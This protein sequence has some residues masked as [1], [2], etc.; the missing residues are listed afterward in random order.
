M[1]PRVPIGPQLPTPSGP[2]EDDAKVKLE[3]DEAEGEYPDRAV[4]ND[5]KG[6]FR[7]RYV[8][9]AYI[10]QPDSEWDEA[11][12][13]RGEADN[14]EDWDGEPLYND[15]D[16]EA[17]LREACY[18]SL[19]ERYLALR[20][21]L[22][23]KPPHSAVEQLPPSQSYH[24]GYFGPKTSVFSVW[25]HRLRNTDPWPAQV[26]SM[27]KDSV[28]RVLRVLMSGKFLRRGYD[29][30]ERTSRWLWA[31]L[32]RLPDRGEMNHI[33][34]GW[35]RDLGR[36]AVLM[37]QSLTH[38]ANLREALQDEGMDLGVHEG[39]DESSDDEDVLADME[40]EED[41]EE[42]QPRREE[43]SI[44]AETTGNAG[45]A[46]EAPENSS[47]PAPEPKQETAPDDDQKSED[48]D[49]SEDGEV[50]EDEPGP[51]AADKE[52]S[53]AAALEAA[54]ARVLA[55]LE[56]EAAPDDD[57]GS[58]EQ[59][60]RARLNMRATLNMILTVAGEFYG[61]RDLLE[62]RDPFTG[63]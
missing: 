15:E 1:A 62:F 3:D 37:T 59:Q 4:Y 26:A 61:Q 44:P 38:M 41:E 13:R 58:A 63:M 43:P 46:L 57:D 33:D 45:E 54:K 48:M 23:A 24:V 18:A 27:D 17:Q 35:V 55:Q 10:G 49:C 6:D 22:Q 20:E 34:V 47:A 52:S 36:R 11:A 42:A 16:T 56:E 31:L 30:K 19:M 51:T 9:G 32:A 60:H 53:D 14:G 12:R 21:R 7:G 40:V 2:T 50:A 29:L 25:N 28:I 8:D 39:I 5:G